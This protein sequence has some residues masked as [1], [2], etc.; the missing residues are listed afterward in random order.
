MVFARSGTAFS[1][2]PTRDAQARPGVPTA[3]LSRSTSALATQAV[4]W[5]LLCS[6]YPNSGPCIPC[7][8]IPAS[9]SSRL[10]C[11]RTSE[12]GRFS[13]SL[14]SPLFVGVGGRPV[15][16][17]NVPQPPRWR[18]HDLPHL[19]ELDLAIVGHRLLQ[20]FAFFAEIRP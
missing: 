1:A 9:G 15:R 14:C 5:A 2:P 3:S 16:H 12:T 19:A 8:R 20:L 7:S 13:R 18:V 17:P 10:C 6:S 4:A 11:L